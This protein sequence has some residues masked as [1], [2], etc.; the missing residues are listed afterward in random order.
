MKLGRDVAVVVVVVVN[1][2]DL[3]DVNMID[4]IVSS[5]TR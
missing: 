2:L 4:D 3:Y 1:D 5:C